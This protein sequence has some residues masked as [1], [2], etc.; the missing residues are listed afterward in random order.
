MSESDRIDAASQAEAPADGH[1][2]DPADPRLLRDALGRF[3]T[4][5]AL[6]TARDIDDGS[7]IAIV[8]NS[9]ASVSL[10]PPLVLWS[11]ACSSMRHRHFTAAPAFAIH[12]LTEAQRDLTARF[13]RSGPG[14]EGLALASNGEGVPILSEALARFDCVTEATH[15]GG[16]H[17]IILGR[18]TRFDLRREGQPLCFF[19]GAFGGFATRD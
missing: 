4:G 16:D 9:F 13:S 10:D 2:P 3:A 5:V 15:A 11:V 17:T 7:P 12:V 14:F 19:G 1:L 6:V 18:V 8:V